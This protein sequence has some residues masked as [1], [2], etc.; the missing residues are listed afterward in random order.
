MEGLGSGGDRLWGN[1]L[2]AME[3][4]YQVPWDL[5]GSTGLQGRGKFVFI[6]LDFLEQL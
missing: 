2:R 6:R 4:R 1:A 3:R 5:G